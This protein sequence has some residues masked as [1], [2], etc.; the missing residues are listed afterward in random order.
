[1][2]GA[3]AWAERCASA[4]RAKG[5][6]QVAQQVVA[7]DGVRGLYRGFGTVI[8]GVIPARGV[9]CS[10]EHFSSAGVC[11]G[12]AVVFNIGCTLL[13][14]YLTTLEA[15]KSWSLAFAQHVTPNEAAAAGLS[16]FCAGA[17]AS[18]ITQSVIVPVD[19]VSQKLMVAG[20]PAPDPHP[21]PP[22]RHMPFPAGSCDGWLCGS[23]LQGGWLPPAA[24][25]RLLRRCP[26]RRRA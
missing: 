24:G 23:G 6:V 16:N 3:P 10:A 8:L 5:A 7:A 1:M 14:V 2:Q 21:A 11:L 9:C 20:L 18:L 12:E 4:A 19:V 15:M 26:A 13:Q 17:T 22:H 25:R